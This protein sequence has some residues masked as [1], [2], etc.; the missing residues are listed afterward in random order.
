MT[1]EA[2]NII[3][4]AATLGLLIGGSIWL[5]YVVQQQ[6]KTKD[7]TIEAL[8]GVA[9]VK[10][11]HILALSGNTAPAIAQAYDVMKT[12]AEDMTGKQLRLSE[13]LKRLTAQLRMKEL[14]QPMRELVCVRR[15]GFSLH[16]TSCMTI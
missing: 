11:A 16:S 7:T 4:N 9:E 14:I 13:E 2:W 15:L 8:K 3:L 10:D 5:R 12:H 1:I 6:L